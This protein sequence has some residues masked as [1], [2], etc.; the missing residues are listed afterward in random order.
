MHNIMQVN[1]LER[2]FFERIVYAQHGFHIGSN[3]GTCAPDYESRSHIR[4]FQGLF[5]AVALSIVLVFGLS[6]AL[7]KR[8]RLSLFKRYLYD[9]RNE[10]CEN[11]DL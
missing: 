10:Q 6:F 9:E 8:L 4:V 5:V 1:E 3:C 7:M 11:T 2:V